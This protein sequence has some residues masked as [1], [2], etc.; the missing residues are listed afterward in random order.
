MRQTIETRPG[1]IST[2]S[3][4]DANGRLVRVIN[5]LGG[6]TVY[7][8]NA[9]GDL[10]SEHSRD[11]AN[12]TVPEQHI[13]YVHDPLGRVRKTTVWSNASAAS[14]GPDSVITKTDYF[15]PGQGSS[16]IPGLGAG[17]IV[18]TAQTN[19]A[20]G[21]T[22]V[23]ADSQGNAT[24]VLHPDPVVGGQPRQID[25]IVY[26]HTSLDLTTRTTTSKPDGSPTLT[27][28][29]S[30]VRSATGTVLATT[31]DAGNAAQ[32]WT[33]MLYN[34]D[35]EQVSLTD[36]VGNKTTWNYD[37]GYEVTTTNSLG[38]TRRTSLNSVG[39]TVKYTDRDGDTRTFDRDALGRVVNEFM[40]S[41]L[42]NRLVQSNTLFYTYDFAERVS[43]VADS[44]GS[45]VL[46]YDNANHAIDDIVT[47][48]DFS[49][50]RVQSVYS[51]VGLR[52][53]VSVTAGTFP[54]ANSILTDNYLYDNQYRLKQVTQTGGPLGSA[55][56]RADC[57]R[58]IIPLMGW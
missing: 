15:L 47:F 57:K 22:I 52:K 48:T 1:A 19:A 55:D 25:T 8:Y 5:E 38:Q 42:A 40:V 37:K 2:I 27:S 30:I 56:K 51:A 20:G 31:Q 18:R 33:R 45:L 13:S 23:A 39:E 16:L 14:P 6:E 28:V 24:T 9:A 41:S 10:T 36:P 26:D 46:G 7:A 49:Q 44:F 35:G 3:Q 32:P 21:V 58:S 53:S 34:T 50:T 29:T 17:Q 54:T 4:F 11:P 43:G 12:P